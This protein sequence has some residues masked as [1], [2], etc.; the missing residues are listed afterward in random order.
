MK[1]NVINVVFIN[2]IIICCLLFSYYIK[3]NIGYVLHNWIII[4]FLFVFSIYSLIVIFTRKK[5]SVF[6]NQFF[7]CVFLCLMIK[8]DIP[9]RF[10]LLVEVPKF[11]RKI[12]SM[13]RKEIED[14]SI[15]LIDE[16]IISDWEPG[17]L[18]YQWVLV[19]DKCDSLQNL[20]DSKKMTSEGKLYILYR[21]KECF[22]LC[23]LYR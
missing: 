8:L 19:Y 20:A 3:K 23:V 11:E 1:K 2:V 13:K 18:D 10:A 21:A 5:K 22:Y 9:D 7:C 12:E 16:Y 17:F 4:L 6:I 14:D 15:K